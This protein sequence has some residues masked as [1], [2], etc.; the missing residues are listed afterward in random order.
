MKTTPVFKAH[1]RPRVGKTAKDRERGVQQQNYE[2]KASRRAWDKD[3][4]VFPAS[5]CNGKKNRF[6]FTGKGGKTVFLK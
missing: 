2:N 3:G 5:T 6:C 1:P 4:G